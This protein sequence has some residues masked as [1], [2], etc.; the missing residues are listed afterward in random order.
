MQ[1]PIVNFHVWRR[2]NYKCKFCFATFEDVPMSE[3]ASLLHD[4]G[5]LPLSAANSMNTVA[6]C[7]AQPSSFVAQNHALYNIATSQCTYGVDELCSLNL[8]VSNQPKCPHQLG[9]QTPL[10]EAVTDIKYPT[11]KLQKAT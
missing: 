10:N 6:S 2:C 5:K 11:G 7:L 4:G 3:C 8:A 9:L 1:L